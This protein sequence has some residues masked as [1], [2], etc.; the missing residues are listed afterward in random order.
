[1]RRLWFDKV[2]D[3]YKGE[4]QEEQADIIDS[5]FSEPPLAE[6]LEQAFHN[7]GVSDLLGSLTKT[8]NPLPQRN[9]L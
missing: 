9:G 8:S 3:Y 1:M 6:A 2:E 7:W 5:P 4:S